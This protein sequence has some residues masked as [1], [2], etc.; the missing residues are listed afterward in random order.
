MWVHA[1]KPSGTHKFKIILLIAIIANTPKIVYTPNDTFATLWSFLSVQE[2]IAVCVVGSKPISMD[3]LKQFKIPPALILHTWV[4]WALPMGILVNTSGV[5]ELGNLCWIMIVMFV[6][7]RPTETLAYPLLIMT[8]SVNQAN[9][10]VG[11]S[12][13]GAPTYVLYAD[14]P[15]WDG[16]NC[17][18]GICCAFNNPPY[19]IKKLTMPSTNYIEARICSRAVSTYEDIAIE[20]LELY[21]K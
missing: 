6:H 10:N 1:C 7:V 19:F 14:D 16:K 4:M 20:E 15:L 9:I 3:I 11:A 13:H 5:L 21:V 2:S 17:L 12:L 18:C 8:T